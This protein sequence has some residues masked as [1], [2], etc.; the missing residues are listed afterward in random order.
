MN[1]YYYSNNIAEIQLSHFMLVSVIE[2]AIAAVLFFIAV[3][4]FDSSLSA[5]GVSLVWWILFFNFYD[6]S[7]S[8]CAIC[9]RFY[10]APIRH[11]ALIY[12]PVTILLMAIGG[13]L[14]KRFSKAEQPIRLFI[15]VLTVFLAATNIVSCISG[16]VAYHGGNGVAF[17]KDFIVAEQGSKAAPKPNIY[18]IHADGMAS[19][20]VVE[21][22]FG[23]KQEVFCQELSKR[24]FLIHRDASFEAGHGSMRAI[25]TLLSPEY[26]DR[27]LYKE[28]KEKAFFQET[29]ES[30]KNLELFAALKAGGYHI[31][32]LSTGPYFLYP[33]DADLFVYHYEGN[34]FITANAPNPWF[35]SDADES[36]SIMSNNQLYAYLRN[37]AYPLYKVFDNIYHFQP[38][39]YSPNE[40]ELARYNIRGDAM[41]DE[42]DFVSSFHIMMQ[43]DI[44][45]QFSYITLET[46]HIPFQYREDG[47]VDAANSHLISSYLGNH[48]YTSK[49]LLDAIDA[50]QAQDPDAVIILQADHGLHTFSDEQ[51]KA[52]FGGEAS[53]REIWNGT[54]SAFCVPGAYRNG[55]ESQMLITPLNISRYLVNNFV[56]AGNYP[57]LTEDTYVR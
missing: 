49:I 33:E 40:Q 14:F 29:T 21:K 13:F 4:A 2:V 28:L 56:G 35:T 18:W 51:F 22:Y 50:I 55:D 41:R 44:P 19:F 53:A 31:K 46:A 27:V 20:D 26:Y 3:L 36:A 11:S 12:I 38:L 30:R 16:N 10:N 17:R 42:I 54:L 1:C 23:D 43:T 24:G 5:L 7:C 47:T 57:Y 15:T 6:Y 25:V 39:P 32:L 52:Q 8:L 48:R 45:P 9:E 37:F 34:G